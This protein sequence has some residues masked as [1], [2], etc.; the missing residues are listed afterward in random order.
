MADETKKDE[1]ARDATDERDEGLDEPETSD[2]PKPAP[3]PRQA[4]RR[5]VILALGAGLV[6]GAG[7]GA[8][9]MFLWGP[10]RRRPPRE[11]GPALGRTYVELAAHN[12]RKGPSPA[13]VT[14]VEFSDF[15]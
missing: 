5:N 15:Q 11:R 3:A 6:C 4:S 10:R 8:G 7:A 13:K 12:P 9:G 2:P 1:A 14:I